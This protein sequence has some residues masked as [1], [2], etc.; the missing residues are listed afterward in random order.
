METR[1]WGLG[2]Q[3]QGYV[4][5][6]GFKQAYRRMSFLTIETGCVEREE[7]RIEI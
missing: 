3:R 6:S 2:T 7:L 4:R 1:D 5:R